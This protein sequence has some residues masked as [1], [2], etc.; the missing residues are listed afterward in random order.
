MPKHEA[1]IWHFVVAVH[2][3]GMCRMGDQETSGEDVFLLF[4]V[5]CIFTTFCLG[6]SVFR[7]GLIIGKHW[8]FGTCGDVFEEASHEE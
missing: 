4:W 1:E 7:F 6:D 8:C 3:L 5:M 2:V